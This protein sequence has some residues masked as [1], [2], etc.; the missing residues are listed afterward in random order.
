MKKVI[1]LKEL[2]KNTEVLKIYEKLLEK[3]PSNAKMWFEKGSI[4]SGFEKEADAL[5][6]Y[7]KV[8]GSNQTM[9]EHLHEKA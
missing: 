2:K 5:L 4:M 6:A 9:L 8:L 3:D 1:L 7:E